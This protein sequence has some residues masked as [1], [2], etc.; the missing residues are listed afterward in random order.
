MAGKGSRRMNAEV[1]RPRYPGGNT[2]V[3]Q[4][5]VCTTRAESVSV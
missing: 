4:Q 2:P 5:V 3:V 1:R